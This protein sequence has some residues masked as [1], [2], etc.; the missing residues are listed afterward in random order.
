MGL[1]VGLVFLILLIGVP[2]C[3]VMGVY[4]LSRRS[5]RPVQTHVVATAPM[6]GA[7]TV[8]TS[9]QA[10][11]STTA[12][13]PLQPAYADTQFSSPSAPS[14]YPDATAYPQAAQVRN[15]TYA[16]VECWALWGS[17][18]KPSCYTLNEEPLP[19]RVGL[20]RK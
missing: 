15:G 19:C 2:L 7:T 1:S 18:S 11:T 12:P 3:I 10:G 6:A 14:T 8:V 17:M 16:L 20:P 4:C 9:S 13:D 5:N